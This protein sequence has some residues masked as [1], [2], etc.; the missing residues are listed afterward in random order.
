MVHVA[1]IRIRT[2]SKVKYPSIPSALRPVFYSDDLPVSIFQSL[3]DLINKFSSESSI[4]QDTEN[5]DGFPTSGSQ[6]FKPK[7]F[8]Q[9]E[10]NNLIRDLS[11]T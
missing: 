6:Y 1:R 10:L 4:E 5:D 11:L 3:K 8:N 2:L 9:S 7:P